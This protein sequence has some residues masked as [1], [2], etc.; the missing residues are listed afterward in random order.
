MP[1]WVAQLFLEIPKAKHHRS[2]QRSKS[3]PE[4]PKMD[5]PGGPSDPKIDE[6]LTKCCSGAL[7]AALGRSGFG[8]ERAGAR[9]ERPLDAKL[10]C[11]GRHV[12]RLGRHVGRVGRQVDGPGRSQDAPKRTRSTTLSPQRVRNAFAAISRA[13]G[14][15]KT[16]VFAVSP[17]C[18]SDFTASGRN[19]RKTSK[20]QAFRLPKSS[21][22]A[23]RTSKSRAKAASASEKVRSKCLRGLRKFKS[24]RERVNFER[25]R[26]PASGQDARA[27]RSPR[28]VFR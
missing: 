12:G 28:G 1:G 6:N 22:R 13:S 9:S 26:A 3:A 23:L 21:P 15:A 19:A 17:P 2:Q 18:V 20:I 8:R 7:Q 27:P 24:E 16:T 14:A 4:K 11:L 5:V 25:A 10:G